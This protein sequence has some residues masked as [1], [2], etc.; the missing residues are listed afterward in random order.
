MYIRVKP[1]KN[2]EYAYL[3][4]NKWDK[5]KKKIKKKTKAYLGRIYK[6]LKSQENPSKIDFDFPK[7]KI[8]LNLLERELYS[9]GFKKQNKNWE[10]KGL[11]VDLFNL[12]TYNKET[13]KPITLQIN[14]GFLNEFTL[15]DLLNFKLPSSIKEINKGKF[16]AKKLL[17]SGISISPQEFISLFKRYKNL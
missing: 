13:Q 2:K 6:P 4:Q 7:N 15:K 12:K 5:R 1:I 17:L 11:V 14:Q 8:I 10:N 9:H 16:L 3:I